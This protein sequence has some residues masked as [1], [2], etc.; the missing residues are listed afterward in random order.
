MKFSMFR[1]G[2]KGERG[3][4]LLEVLVGLAI[5][6]LISSASS[7][8]VMQMLRVNASANNRVTAI[9]Q[10]QNAGYWLSRDAQQAR[11]IL[12]GD[13]PYTEETTEDFVAIFS[14]SEWDGTKDTIIYEL[15]GNGGLVRSHYQGG[16]YYQDGTLIDE[17]TIARFITEASV[18]ID[19]TS[20]YTTAAIT[21]TVGGFQ[22]VS[23]TR[24][25]EIV[26][27]TRM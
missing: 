16:E 24:V 9:T 1:P 8:V 20:L 15:D 11:V 13:D 26:P 2:R 14:W 18:N 27:R 21:A 17:T 22:R 7:V 6:A 23:E 5:F 19:E 10:V 3:L 25:Y 12:K 4:G